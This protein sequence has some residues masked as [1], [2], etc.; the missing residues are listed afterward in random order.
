MIIYND[1]INKFEKKL[2]RLLKKA[3]KQ[4]QLLDEKEMAKHGL[5]IE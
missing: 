5:K 1:F 3:E 4:G 2:F